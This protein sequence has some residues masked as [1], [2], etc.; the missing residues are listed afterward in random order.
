MLCLF[1]ISSAQFVPW[2]HYKVKVVYLNNCFQNNLGV[3]YKINNK[4]PP[5]NQLYLNII[6]D[7]NFTIWSGLLSKIIFAGSISYSVSIVSGNKRQHCKQGSK[8]LLLLEMSVLA[9]KSVQLDTV[10]LFQSALG[11][12]FFDIW[13][14]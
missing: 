6:I 1:Q 5:L 2:Q 7:W 3:R 13:T 14:L 12:C 9:K 11:K 4:L 10:T 8:I